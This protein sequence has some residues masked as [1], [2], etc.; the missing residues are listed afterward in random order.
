MSFGDIKNMFAELSGRADLIDESL[1]QAVGASFFINSGQKLLDKLLVGNKSEG[2]YFIDVDYNQ[3]LVPIPGC[4]AVM[5]VFVYDSEYRKELLKVDIHKLREY[6]NEPVSS[7]GSSS[8]AYYSPIVIK[9]YPDNLTTSGYNQ[10]W[11]MEDILTTGSHAFN[12]ILIMPPSDSS[13]SYTLEVWGLFKT[14]ELVND[15]DETFWTEEYP[16][17]LLKASL[18]QLETFY[19]NT[20]GAKDWMNAITL[21]IGEL[22]KDSVA[23]EIEEID[24]F[25]G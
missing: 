25:G 3:I 12:A 1:G 8:P 19:R 10:E 6:Y 22:I 17:L 11:S 9:P 21:E 16:E 4:R 5:R 2:R 7:M 15:S 20:E 23:E 13:T 18:Y 14:D 24:S